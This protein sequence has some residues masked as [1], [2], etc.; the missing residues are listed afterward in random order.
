MPLHNDEMRG[1]E[2][3]GSKSHEYCKYC[4]QNGAFTNPR[5]NVEQMAARIISKLEGDKAP[6]GIIESAVNRLRNFKRWRMK[7]S[8]VGDGW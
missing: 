7:A 6:E 2:Q 3:D 5:I 4:Y 1:T 8:T